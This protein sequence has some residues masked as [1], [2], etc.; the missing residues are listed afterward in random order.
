MKAHDDL[1]SLT[2]GDSLDI[3]ETF[4]VKEMSVSGNDQCSTVFRG[5]GEEKVIK[6]ICLNDGWNRFR[7]R[8]KSDKIEEICHG[9]LWADLKSGKPVREFWETSREYSSL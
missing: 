3:A 1:H 7:I 6:G 9:L 5:K 4:Q 2:R 8:Y